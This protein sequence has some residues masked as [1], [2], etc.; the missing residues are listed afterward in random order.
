MY[1]ADHLV[2][3]VPQKTGEILTEDLAPSDSNAYN[4]AVADLRQRI[5]PPVPPR[6]PSI[7]PTSSVPPP[8][9]PNQPPKVTVVWGCMVGLGGGPGVDINAQA[10]QIAKAEGYSPSPSCVA[11]GKANHQASVPWRHVIG[12]KPAFQTCNGQWVFNELHMN[13]ISKRS[14]MRP[15]SSTL[16]G[17]RCRVTVEPNNRRL[18]VNALIFAYG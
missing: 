3:F 2:L 16:T 8:Q 6:D 13:G 5:V 7:T 18:D 11:W 17:I 4:H 1:Q 12:Q 15:G 9:A 14:G 10:E